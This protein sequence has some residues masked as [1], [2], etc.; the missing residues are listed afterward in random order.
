MAPY[1][2]T[3]IKYPDGKQ[4]ILRNID[5]GGFAYYKSGRKAICISAHGWDGGKQS[6]RRYGA[7]VHADNPGSTVLGTFDEWGHGY[8]EAFRPPD[9]LIPPSKMLVRDREII[10]LEGDGKSST[11]TSSGPNATTLPVGL[12]LNSQIQVQHSAGRTQL[13][14]VGDGVEHSFDIGEMNGMATQGMMDKQPVKDSHPELQDLGKTLSDLMDRVASLRVEPSQ[15]K[16]LKDSK[17][18]LFSA[19]SPELTRAGSQTLLSPLGA[20]LHMMGDPAKM[21]KML[22]EQHPPCPG[23][24]GRSGRPQKWT[25]ANVSGRLSLEKLAHVK[26]TVDAPS[27]LAEVSQVKLQSLIEGCAASHTL[28][29]VICL[30]TFAAEQS[31]YA[32]RLA[33]KAHTDLLKRYGPSSSG[34]PA[35]VQMVAVELSEMPLL[36]KQYNIREAPYC[37]MFQH[38]GLVYSQRL[39]G[40]KLLAK[41]AFS[42][43]PHVLLVEPTPVLQLKLE[44]ALRRSGCTSDL[45][46]EVQ[47]G[48]T[49]ASKSRGYGLLVVTADVGVE[50]IGALITA[51]QQ[52]EPTAK[53]VVYNA[54]KDLKSFRGLGDSCAHVFPSLPS[55]TGLSTVLAK[56]DLASRMSTDV[57]DGKEAFLADVINVLD[58]GRSP[59]GTGNLNLTVK[60]VWA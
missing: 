3:D 27:T 13:R 7:V 20:S 22:R 51:A 58:N 47:S 11:F 48:I 44:K 56:T 43:R 9:T 25:I 21:R 24:L 14:F 50:T 10:L 46:L 39:S 57:G 54:G 17:G 32:R 1:D 18:Q 49:M 60:T 23:P 5:G 33:E 37:L 12:S 31:N 52:L 38:G 55:W 34:S 35:P 15:P 36:A 6:Y 26:P 40:M 30:A 28:L 53:V 19:S 2:V 4:A 8:V 16:R 42:G 45:A 59:A 41:E 29:V